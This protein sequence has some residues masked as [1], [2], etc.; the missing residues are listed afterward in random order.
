MPGLL[1]RT[2]D[3]N[4][5][6]EVVTTKQTFLDECWAVNKLVLSESWNT[7]VAELLLASSRGDAS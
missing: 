3:H 2:G 1:H 4:K 7:H 6:N 5:D